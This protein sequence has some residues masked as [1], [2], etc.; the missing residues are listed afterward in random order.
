MKYSS[1]PYIKTE[2]LYPGAQVNSDPMEEG[3][4]SMWKDAREV[5]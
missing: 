1:Q 5:W 4:L 3:N 2:K